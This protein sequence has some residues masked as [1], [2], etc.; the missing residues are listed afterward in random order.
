M[1]ETRET[2]CVC[3]S[4]KAHVQALFFNVHCHCVPAA[5]EPDDVHAIHGA[6][7][8][9]VHPGEAG[10]AQFALDCRVLLGIPYDQEFD[11][12]FHCKDPASG[13]A[14]QLKGLPAYDA[15]MHCALLNAV[16][17]TTAAAGAAG[18]AAAT[19]AAA[20]GNSGC[21]VAPNDASPEPGPGLGQGGGSSWQFTD[22]SSVTT[23]S[24]GGS[25]YSP[26]AAAPAAAP[27]AALQPS[28]GSSSR[29]TARRAVGSRNSDAS[30]V[31]SAPPPSS[32]LAR[33]RCALTLGSS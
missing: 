30:A 16:T 22:T 14:V 12:I 8:I 9:R 2:V 6:L 25:N 15:A 1:G 20:G 13:S 29:A 11:V 31:V 26:T 27:P 7:Q 32:F 5:F 21:H 19:A 33:L 28:S 10:R 3:Y 18:Q 24:G 23:H 17:K 4:P